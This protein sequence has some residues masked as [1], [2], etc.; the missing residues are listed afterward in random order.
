MGRLVHTADVHLHP[1]APERRQALEALLD[2]AEST[3]AD[4]VTIGGDLFEDEVAAERLRPELRS[5]F[6]DRPYPV[7]LIPGNHDREAYEG[8]VF[9][10]AAVRTATVEPFEHVLVERD[11]AGSGGND[12]V[13]R[14]TCVPYTRELDDDLLVALRDREPFDGPEYLLVHC[15]LEAPAAT[16]DT[17]DEE[18]ARYAPVTRSEL[19]ALEFDAVLAGHYH[20]ANRVGLPASSAES[21]AADAGGTFVYPGTPASVTTAETGRRSIAI[22]D[23]GATPS[24]ALEPLDSFHYDELELTVRPGDAKDAIGT[25]REQV[26]TWAHRD[27]EAEIAIEGFV[28]RDEAM[29]AAEL[30]DA[31]G[32][33]PL[34]N[35]TRS[36]AHLLDHPIYR[37]FEARI[38]ADT[39]LDATENEGHDP[40]QLLDDARERVLAAMADLA[41]EGELS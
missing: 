19:G 1:D 25:V 13:S 35:R 23:D 26:A 24:V 28:D 2:R 5:L 11:A 6:S 17:G 14:I 38:D 4:A 30:A 3:D 22:V 31:A 9:F 29:F 20:G 34:E 18:A 36:V 21:N 41:A 40:D 27:V 37:E 16:A 15:S 7:V 12:L 8:D 39:A 32:D 33:V 10:G